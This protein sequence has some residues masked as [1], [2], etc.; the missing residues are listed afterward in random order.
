MLTGFKDKHVY[1]LEGFILINLKIHSSIS[2]RKCIAV[3]REN[4]QFNRGSKE[5]NQSLSLGNSVRSDL[6]NHEGDFVKKDVFS[7]SHGRKKQSN[8]HEESNLGR[9]DSAP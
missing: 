8:P 1:Q 5:L 7:F 3:S 6:R 2:P 4:Y 9:S